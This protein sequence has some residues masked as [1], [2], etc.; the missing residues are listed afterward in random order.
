MRAAGVVQIAAPNGEII[1]RTSKKLDSYNLDIR[2]EYQLLTTRGRGYL[3]H[4][5]KDY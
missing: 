5:V 2:R 1:Y 4:N 3:Q